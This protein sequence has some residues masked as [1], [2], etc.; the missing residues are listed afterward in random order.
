M[1]DAPPQLTGQISSNA[2]DPAAW[3]DLV[4]RSECITS[5]P[6]SAFLAGE[7]VALQGGVAV[8][9]RVPQRVYVGIEVIG[10][11][12]AP[13]PGGPSI[14]IGVASD[15]L[16]YDPSSDRWN[17]V[18]WL[19]E[20]EASSAAAYLRWNVI[21]IASRL[22]L[23]GSLLKVRSRHILRPSAGCNW[24]GAFSSA[25]VAALYIL[26]GELSD[27]SVVEWASHPIELLTQA[28]S[29]FDRCNRDA[30]RIDNVFH[31]GKASGYG[32]F[33]SLIGGPDPLLYVTVERDRTAPF[34][35]G[36][37]PYPVDLRGQETLLDAIPY[38]GARIVDL[39]GNP[40][41]ARGSDHYP[42]FGIIVVYSGAKKSTSEAVDLTRDDLTEQLEEGASSGL[43]T[44]S[45]RE[46][47]AVLDQ[48]LVSQLAGFSGRQLRHLSVNALLANGLVVLNT[49]GRLYQNHQHSEEQ[50]LIERLA[51]AMRRVQGSLTQLG[52]DWPEFYR[53]AATVYRCAEKYGIYGSTAVKLTG[54]GRGGCVVCVV[55]LT[56]SR[57]EDQPG[58]LSELET[59]LTGLGN[60]SGDDAEIADIHVDWCSWRDG[61]EGHGLR[62]ERSDGQGEMTGI[63]A[64]ARSRYNSTEV[65]FVT[66]AVDGL[67]SRLVD[68]R[69]EICG[70]TDMERLQGSGVHPA[71]DLCDL[72]IVCNPPRA[73]AV[74]FA[75]GDSLDLDMLSKERHGSRY[76]LALALA[77]LSRNLS[78]PQQ[79]AHYI[80][81]QISPSRRASQGWTRR[82]IQNRLVNPFNELITDLASRSSGYD[83]SVI[84]TLRL[85]DHY[86]GASGAEY[87]FSITFNGSGNG[88]MRVGVANAAFLHGFLAASPTAQARIARRGHRVGRH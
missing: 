25:L 68:R 85:E 59:S 8:C 58:F 3:N 80:C 6:G 79:E 36:T 63:P 86:R 62:V 77:A 88:V 38:A 74:L 75:W 67:F 7:H 19:A 28:G 17:E 76:L 16:V 20:K 64:S 52:L 87:N 40:P 30:W 35:D 56:G 46:F 45:K 72:F 69:R 41:Q 42:G 81:E 49:L 57:R 23:P 27:K 2:E 1:I 24:S 66:I 60:G 53:I 78:I 65:E 32:S 83:R 50:Q 70:P 33:C 34:P 43:N 84:P 22:T 13:E 51:G 31:G 48:T 73:E 5:C 39:A 29:I 82:Y 44:L 18:S 12:C 15:H 61:L 71:D 37:G 11:G 14:Q 54:G 26:A 21:K 55:P 4:Q 10:R 9:I 47:R